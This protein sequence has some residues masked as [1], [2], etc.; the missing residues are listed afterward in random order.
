MY[1]KK[2]DL[3]SFGKF[4]NKSIKFSRGLNIVYGVNEAGKT[5]IHDFIEGIFYGFLKPYVKRV[6]YKEKHKKYKPWNKNL[7]YGSIEFDYENKPFRI[8]RNFIKGN[9]YT[10]IFDLYTGEDI[11]KKINMN[12]V[13]RIKQPGNY[14][15]G[16]NDVV[17]LNTISVGQLK[18]KTEK[19]LAYEVK[20]K[21]INLSTS[22]N[23]N[24]SIK[25]VLLDLDKKKKLIGNKNA[26]T[27]EYGLLLSKKNKL[28]NR[29][30]EIEQ[31][32]LEFQ[33][34]NYILRKKYNQLKIID[35]EIKI[36]LITKELNDYKKLKEKYNNLIKIEQE[37]KELKLN[38]NN[39]LYNKNITLEEYTNVTRNIEDLNRYD[40]SIE[41]LKIEKENLKIKK[42]KLEKI[43]KNNRGIE[44]IEEDYIDYLKLEK[45][46]SLLNSSVIKEKF[47]IKRKEYLKLQDRIKN[48]KNK[49]K[50]SILILSLS[51]YLYLTKKS[52]ILLILVFLSCIMIIYLILDIKYNNKLLSKINKDLLSIKEEL[53]IVNNNKR[54]YEYNQK[55]IL[56]KY[57]I[58]KKNDFEKLYNFERKLVYRKINM[59]DEIAEIVDKIKNKDNEISKLIRKKDNCYTYINKIFNKYNIT[60][61]DQ[62][63]EIYVNKEK[64]MNIV[65]KI[66]SNNKLMKGILED[67]S[68]KQITTIVESKKYLEKFKND[69][70]DLDNKELNIKINRKRKER[71][72]LLYDVSKLNERISILEENKKALLSIKEEI[73]YLD[74]MKNK[75]EED[76]YILNLASG[77][78]SK[79]SKEIQKRFIP[80]L[81]YDV[82][83]IIKEISNNKYN[84]VKID[85]DLNISVK[86]KH[87]KKIVDLSNLSG[88]T[89]DQLYFSLRYSLLSRIN[90]RNPLILDDTFTQYDDIRLE[91]ILR[92]L[93]KE[94][95]NRQIILFTC[96]KRE[97]DIL[98]K[99]E[100]KYNLIELK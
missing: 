23:E 80:T 85:N 57:N 88:G 59:T 45:N 6:Y 31:K 32:I 84:N 55:N 52:T 58:D 28:N 61:V 78:I 22:K 51:I 66:E 60:K 99:N 64:Y 70:L 38:L 4:H 10:K 34:N 76:I 49:L 82:S 68:K 65:R 62:L 98:N 50:I 46:I 71:E 63:K 72:A 19:D 91:N 53:Y 33:D 18:S 5:T 95:K 21:L 69:A 12:N 16:M 39:I 44:D 86:D 100:M 36:L 77:I 35:K 67:Y 81:N 1:I 17:F 73:T 15:L 90:Y 74:N 54:K 83:K 92:F 27:S 29:K 93:L 47:K 2:L 79:K 37:N 42:E 30:I 24:L 13:T 87:C 26:P 89:I 56:D 48:Y 94:S 41:K 75:M 3:T 20:D 97:M 7:Y 43:K 25:K 11:S 14:F 9:E 40:S 8:E 96:Q